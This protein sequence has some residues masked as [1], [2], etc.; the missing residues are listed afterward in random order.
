MLLFCKDSHHEHWAHIEIG[1]LFLTKH[2]LVNN[3]SATYFCLPTS[4]CTC[5]KM[6]NVLLYF[7]VWETGQS[8]SVKRQGIREPEEAIFSHCFV[9]ALW[10]TTYNT[11]LS[12]WST[13][14]DIFMF[15]S[16]ILYIHIPKPLV[17]Q[18]YIAIFKH[19][20]SIKRTVQF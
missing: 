16:H 14:T 12:M 19:K 17:P 18:K 4:V 5:D 3:L 9:C 13:S 1:D 10:I 6:W 7:W 8:V 20:T 2:W 11:H 15:I